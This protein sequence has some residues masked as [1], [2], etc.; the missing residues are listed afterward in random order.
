[1][2]ALFVSSV[3][4]DVVSQVELKEA[5][6]WQSLRLPNAMESEPQIEFGPLII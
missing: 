3:A 1:M 5:V 6:V 4:A 2:F